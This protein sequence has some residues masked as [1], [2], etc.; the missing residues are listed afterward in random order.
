M[1]DLSIEKLRAQAVATGK[2]TEAE[3]QKMNREELQNWY[4]TN[5]P[6]TNEVPSVEES[7]AKVCEEHKAKRDDKKQE[8]SEAK[9]RREYAKAIKAAYE[10]NKMG[11]YPVEHGRMPFLAPLVTAIGALITMASCG[12]TY[13]VDLPDV[14]LDQDTT[15]NVN[16]TMDLGEVINLLKENNELLKAIGADNEANFEKFVAILQDILNNTNYL[17]DGMTTVIEYLKQQGI[18]QAQILKGIAEIQNRGDAFEENQKT[19][20]NLLANGNANFAE[21][22]KKILEAIK[23]FGVLTKENGELLNQILDKLATIDPSDPKTLE[24][25]EQILAKITENVEATKNGNVQNAENDAITHKYLEELLKK[26]TSLDDTAKDLAIKFVKNMD[27]LNG[28]FD[29][30]I[31]VLSK[32][33][34]GNTTEINLED[35]KEF[36][37]VYFESMLNDNEKFKDLLTKILNKISNCKGCEC[38]LTELLAKLDIIIQKLEKP[39]GDDDTPHEGILDDL[40]DIL[41]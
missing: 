37:K 41:K 6:D 18:T 4:K 21:Y 27:K 12:D 38:D 8:I 11:Q 25:L 35:L 40:D 33:S 10:Y 19:I 2:I 16:I 24:L 29:K 5:F 31:D 36:L 15:V 39:S 3:A 30:A 22:L 26:M 34:T 9:S 23:A 32:L 14:D 17:A 1:V 13:N 20:I 28:K 7:W